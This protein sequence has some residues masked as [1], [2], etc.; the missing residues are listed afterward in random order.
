[1]L[2]AAH[3]CIVIFDH[4]VDRQHAQ[5]E[6]ISFKRVGTM[7]SFGKKDMDTPMFTSLLGL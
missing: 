3:H 6:T 1:M 2:A 7:K 4:V 5:A